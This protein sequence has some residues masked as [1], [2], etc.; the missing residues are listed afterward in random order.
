LETG[1]Q[2]FLFWKRFVTK[3]IPIRKFTQLIVFGNTVQQ[4]E[5]HG[6][7]HWAHYAGL[8]KSD[9]RWKTVY[10]V[11]LYQVKFS[12]YPDFKIFDFGGL[13]TVQNSDKSFLRKK[14][15]RFIFLFNWGWSLVSKMG[16]YK[17]APGAVFE[18]I[19]F[20]GNFWCL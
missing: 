7:K 18:K 10:S 5:N 19:D 6:N 13:P 2:I 15:S 4:I 11:W 20:R 1:K 9:E 12:G 14:G 17:I 3:R 16:I 8:V